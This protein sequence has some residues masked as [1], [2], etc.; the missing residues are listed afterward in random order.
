[1]M[2]MMMMVMI[3][4]V[5]DNDDDDF[6]TCSWKGMG[7]A[8]RRGDM[9]VRGLKMSNHFNHINHHLQFLWQCYIKVYFKMKYQIKT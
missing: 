4:F 6:G 5:K 3:M 8:L 2:M 7:L 1:M 9:K